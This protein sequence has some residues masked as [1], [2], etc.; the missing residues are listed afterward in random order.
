VA[1]ATAAPP[2][3]TPSEYQ[4]KAVFIYNF[5]RFVAWP[6]DAFS[7][8]GEPFVIGVLGSDPFGERLDEAV[9]GEL[10]GQHPLVVRRFSDV[11]QIGDCRNQF[12]DPSEDARLGKILATLDHHSVLTVSDVDDA[13]ARGVMIQLDTEDN[14][15]RL[16]VNVGSARAAGLRISSNL[17]RLAQVVRGPRD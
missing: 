4:V 10:I 17:L 9:R 15:V 16:R 6:A 13:T 3:S 11:S 5:S 2:V 12:I 8:P 1:V 14:R 7:S